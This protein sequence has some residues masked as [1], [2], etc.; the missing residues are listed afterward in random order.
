MTGSTMAAAIS[1]VFLPPMPRNS[2]QA[3]IGMVIPAAIA[4]SICRKCRQTR[5]GAACGGLRARDDGSAHYAQPRCHRGDMIY[6]S[7]L[8]GSGFP[9]QGEV[10]ADG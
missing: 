7:S 3:T 1:E 5:A 9:W 8:V 2:I 10:T 4:A 6:Q